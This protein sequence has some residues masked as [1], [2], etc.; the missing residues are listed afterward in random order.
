MRS[1][2]VLLVLAT[3]CAHPVA[4]RRS[5]TTAQPAAP[6]AGPIATTWV[7]RRVNDSHARLAQSEVGRRVRAAIDAHGGLTAYFSHGTLAFDFDYQPLAHPERRMFSHNRVDLW[8]ARATQRELGE[9]ADATLGWD[10]RDAWI[11]PNAAAFASPAR[12]WATTPFYFVAIPFV[13]ADPGVRL[14]AL[15]DESLDG[16]SHQMVKVTYESGT[17]DSSGDYYV[18]YL[19]PE[20]HRV[21]AIRYVVAYPGFFPDGGHSPEKLM[22]YA[23]LHAVGGVLMP[24]RLDTF[25]YNPE[26]HAPGERVT[27]IT[28]TNVTMGERWPGSI[29]APPTGAVISTLRDPR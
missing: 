28:V 27:A 2:C 6:V 13:F 4:P 1:L 15:A 11:V 26:T 14:E 3:A 8:R 12:F 9:G 24:S 19:H 10:G 7:A 5:A 29:F 16:V 18:L 23:D 20:N 25:A 17:G 22:R 21:S